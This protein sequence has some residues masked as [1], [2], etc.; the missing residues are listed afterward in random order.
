MGSG[1]FVVLDSFAGWWGYC[2]TLRRR[3]GEGGS[4]PLAPRERTPQSLRRQL[5]LAGEPGVGYNVAGVDIG[6]AAVS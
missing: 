1:S 4:A 6:K 3:A 5:P 2:P